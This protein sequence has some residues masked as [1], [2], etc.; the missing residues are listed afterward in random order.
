MQCD[1][2]CCV[3]WPYVAQGNSNGAVLSLRIPS[4]VLDEHIRGVLD[5]ESIKHS[6]KCNHRIL[7]QEK[8]LNNV[9]SA[10]Y[11]FER[12]SQGKALDKERSS[13]AAAPR[14][15]NSPTGSRTNR[16][17]LPRDWCACDW[18]S[19]TVLLC[20]K[21]RADVIRLSRFAIFGQQL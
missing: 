15:T 19:A 6:L 1:R 21:V 5:D 7:P 11:S 10:V 2:L 18:C 17:G 9:K 12:N 13:N 20:A 4:N 16:L 14:E 8:R 3:A